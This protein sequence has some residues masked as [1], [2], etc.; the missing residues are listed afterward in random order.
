MTGMPTDKK[1]WNKITNYFLN[2]IRY[3]FLNNYEVKIEIYAWCN[4]SVAFII[5][6]L[7]ACKER[8]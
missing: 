6:S 5:L 2:I 4:L 8:D 7:N 3:T 1:F